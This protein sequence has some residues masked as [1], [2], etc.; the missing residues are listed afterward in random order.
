MLDLA[1]G[2]AVRAQAG[3]RSRYEPAESA[4]APD[5]VGEAGAAHASVPRPARGHRPATSPTWMRSRAGPSSAQCC[6][7]WRSSRPGLPA[8]SWWMPARTPRRAPSRCSPR[9]RARWSSGWRRCSAFTDLRAIVRIVGESRVV[10]SLDLRHGQSH[11]ASGHAGRRRRLPGRAEPRGQAVDTGV[12]QPGRA[13][14]GADRHR[15]RHGPRL[16][17]GAAEALPGDPADGGGW[18][19]RAS[20]PRPDAGRRLRRGAGGERHSRRH[21]HSRR[22]GGLWPPCRWALSR[23]ASRGRWRTVRSSPRPPARAASGG[24]SRPG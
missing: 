11:H 3:D 19:A 1:R 12:E 10:F 2:V 23:R 22:P 13:G 14:P 20:G 17:R 6:A 5:A 24:C 8:P 7:S 16:A 21:D 9:A 15:M 18:R 4:L